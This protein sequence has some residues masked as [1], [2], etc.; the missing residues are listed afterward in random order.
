MT[1]SGG[2]A[3]LERQK[4]KVKAAVLDGRLHCDIYCAYMKGEIS[5]KDDWQE[6]AERERAYHIVSQKVFVEADYSQPWEVER[7]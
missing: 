7:W 3:N 2:L 4:P 5:G 6:R 1:C